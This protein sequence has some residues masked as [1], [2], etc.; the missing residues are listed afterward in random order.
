MADNKMMGSL[1]NKLCAYIST[2]LVHDSNYDIAVL[3]LKNYDRLKGM[4]IAEVADLCYVSQSAISRFCRFFGLEN[5]KEF[6]NC[7]EDEFSVKNDYSK[8]FY[9]VLSSNEERAMS[10]YRDELIANIYGTISP[11]NI[12]IMPDIIEELHN[13]GTVAYFSHH[14][15]WDIGRFFQSKMMLMDQYV[16]QYIDYDAQLQCAKTLKKGDL[17]IVC[18]VGGSYITRYSEIWNA[19]QD[20][21]CKILVITQN[22]SSAH[23]NSVDYILQCGVTNRD[24]V[25]KYA[26]L[27]ITDYMVMSYMKKYNKY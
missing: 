8:Q 14:F 25:G 1:A 21:G 2:T 11:E 24:D 7:L 9:A 5:F 22:L 4:N 18:T 10:L 26:A 3:L 20:S 16:E 23:L 17:A 15:L 13:A 6:K 19:I 12:E 27:M